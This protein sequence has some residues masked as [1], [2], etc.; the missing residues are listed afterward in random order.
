MMAATGITIHKSVRAA[1][2]FLRDNEY[3]RVRKFWLKNDRRAQV[4]KLPSG[5]VRVIEGMP[6]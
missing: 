3:D 1:H 2:K 5:K 6:A 4:V